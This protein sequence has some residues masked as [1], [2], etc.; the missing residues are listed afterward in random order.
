V[1][2]R[3]G[4]RVVGLGTVEANGEGVYGASFTIPADARPGIAIISVDRAEAAFTVAAAEI[5][6]TGLEASAPLAAASVMLLL[7]TAVLAYAHRQK[8]T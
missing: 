4:S 7:G 3:Q 6:D 1:E 2:F 8:R 5:P